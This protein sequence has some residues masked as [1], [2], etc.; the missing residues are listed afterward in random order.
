[1]KMGPLPYPYFILS[2]TKING[3]ALESG[4]ALKYL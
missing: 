1:M 2:V 3:R 4:G